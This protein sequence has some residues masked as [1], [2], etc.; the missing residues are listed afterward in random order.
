VLFFKNKPLS[1]ALSQSKQKAP[2]SFGNL[3][4]YNR[5][6]ALKKAQLPVAVLG[7]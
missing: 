6:L 1:P 2:F 5:Y 4:I 3:S 7:D